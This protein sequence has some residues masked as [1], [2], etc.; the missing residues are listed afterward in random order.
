MSHRDEVISAEQIAQ[1]VLGQ[2]SGAAARSVD[3]AQAH[4]RHLRQKLEEDPSQPSIIVTVGR[5]G[6]RFVV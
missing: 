6:Y 5:K 2:G 4:I 3:A 1:R